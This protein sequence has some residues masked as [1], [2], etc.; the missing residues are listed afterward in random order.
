MSNPF[1]RFVVQPFQTISIWLVASGLL[2]VKHLPPSG[3]IWS[4]LAS[5]VSF[6]TGWLPDS[7]EFDLI[8]VRHRH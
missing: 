2:S 3:A 8:C 1:K 7:F 4:D 5:L 6:G